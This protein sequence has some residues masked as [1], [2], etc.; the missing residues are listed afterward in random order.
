LR[1]VCPT[2]PVQDGLSS[3]RLQQRSRFAVVQ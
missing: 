2:S 3:I 1:A